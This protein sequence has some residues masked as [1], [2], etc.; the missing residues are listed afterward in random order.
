MN[1]TSK[2]ME[3]NQMSYYKDLREHIKA[4]EANNNLVIVTREINRDTELMPLVRWQYRGLAEEE[5]KSFLFENVVDVK[6]K[7]Y[8][9]PVLVGSYAASIQIYA[10]GM[11]CEPDEIMEKWTQAQLNPI[12]PK[13]VE[14]GPVHEEVHLG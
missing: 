8:D 13:M 9:M 1:A 12:E 10:I 3:D 2:K 7:K 4:L 11:M 5:R 14:D 6:G